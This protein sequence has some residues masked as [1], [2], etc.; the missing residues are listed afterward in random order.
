MDAVGT[1]RSCSFFAWKKE[2]TVIDENGLLNTRQLNF[3]QRHLARKFCCMVEK[4][5]LTFFQKHCAK[6][7][8]YYSHTRLAYV[9]EKAQQA[10][11][12]SKYVYT[13]VGKEHLKNLIW[14]ARQLKKIQEFSQLGEEVFS[15]KS[16]MRYFGGLGDSDTLKFMVSYIYK[17][18]EGTDHRQSQIEISSKDS[19]IIIKDLQ[20]TFTSGN[21]FL[22]KPEDPLVS[23]TY[24]FV[25]KLLN[26][27]KFVDSFTVSGNRVGSGTIARRHGFDGKRAEHRMTYNDIQVED[28][29]GLQ[30]HKQKCPTYANLCPLDD[31]IS[32]D[33]LN[34]KVTGQRVND[35]CFT[36]SS[37]PT[38]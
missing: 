11:F 20:E 2:Y 37:G 6:T 14:K 8:A 31:R 9:A 24:N 23:A 26:D 17:E 13:P 4:Y 25:N 34:P 18:G 5:S 22:K 12:K 10:I 29:V 33:F 7:I 1:R 28:P 36:P 30:L 27:S 32:V 3:F 21:A 16:K 15:D 19:S 35:F 38:N